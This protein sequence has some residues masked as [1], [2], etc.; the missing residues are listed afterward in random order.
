[1]PAPACVRTGRTW[2][3]GPLFW[4]W[5]V[6]NQDSNETQIC[7]YSDSKAQARKHR[8][9]AGR[10]LGPPDPGLCTVRTLKLANCPKRTMSKY[11]KIIPSHTMWRRGPCFVTS[12]QPHNCHQYPS[13]IGCWRDFT[14]RLMYISM[15]RVS[16]PKVCR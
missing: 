5:I 13:R 14:S 16:H 12:L 7:E 1:V 8:I 2:D 15:S 11:L 6:D 4:P 9:S 10:P 3:L